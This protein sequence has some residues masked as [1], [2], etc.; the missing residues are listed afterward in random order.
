MKRKMAAA[1]C[2][3]LILCLLSGCRLAREDAGQDTRE[4]RLIGVFITTEYIDLFDFD[5]YLNDNIGSFKGGEI[6]VDGNSA[7][8]QGRLYAV[9]TPRT[10]TNDETGEA[11]VT[12][13]YVF[14]DLAG[15][16]YFVPTIQPAEDENSYI[17]TMSDTA[18]SDGHTSIN[19]GDDKNSIILDGTIYVASSTNN[20][21]YYFNHV[22]PSADGSVYLVT[23]NG[24]MLS[25]IVESEGAAMSQTLDE[26]YT[27]TEN[28]KT[29]TDSISIKISVSVMFAPE[30]IAIVQMNANNA[31][32]SR[33]EYAPGVMPETLAP[34]GDMAYLIVETQKRDETG[35]LKISREIYDRGAESIETFYARADGICVKQWTKITLE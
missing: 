22:Y 16:P 26:V 21:T 15:I 27:E 13:E 17:A 25:G 12:H 4:D 18:V 11:V 32:I 9:L 8:Y 7:K 29:R 10:L 31:L 24:L 1:L 30:K 3:A 28:G 19:V 14:E 35:D 23:G 5:S 2:C 34:E 33:T 6:S 20:S